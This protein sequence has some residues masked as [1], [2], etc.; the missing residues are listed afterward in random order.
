MAPSGFQVLASLSGAVALAED[1]AFEAGDRESVAVVAEKRDVEAL[2]EKV[3]GQWNTWTCGAAFREA[4]AFARGLKELGFVAG[5][6]LLLFGQARPRLLW[7]A[8][9]AQALGGKSLLGG[10]SA[11]SAIS[12]A[13]ADVRFV[14]IGEGAA[15]GQTAAALGARFPS[16]VGIINDGPDVTN[17]SDLVER[18]DRWVS[19]ESVR[20]FGW[21]RAGGAN[22]SREPLSNVPST[23]VAWLDDRGEIH[24]VDATRARLFESEG[25]GRRAR[26]A[27]DVV[28]VLALEPSAGAARVAFLIAHWKDV[29]FRL[30]LPERRGNLAIDTRDARPTHLFAS[31]DWYSAFAR[32]VHERLPAF[33]SLR[34]RFIDAALRVGRRA[35]DL[36]RRGGR[37]SLDAA[38]WSF[39]AEVTVLRPLRRA[40]GLGHVRLAFSVGAPLGGDAEEVLNALGIRNVAIRQ[41]SP[42]RGSHS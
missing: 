32:D 33:G 35:D 39:L 1:R 4:D 17:A 11:P 18:D 27:S 2:R 37:L 21:G 29:G 12:G 8:L 15:R 40:L 30:S 7:A 5:D 3:R 23:N 14:F 36:R 26:N 31:D 10:E 41:Q 25:Q 42:E 9:G 28:D 24:E 13:V 16:A 34:R 19:F 38:A 22:N 20:R 6:T